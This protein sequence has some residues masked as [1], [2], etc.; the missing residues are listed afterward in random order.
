MYKEITNWTEDNDDMREYAF[1][2]VR[3]EERK[4]K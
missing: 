3:Q 1:Y 2:L 4:T